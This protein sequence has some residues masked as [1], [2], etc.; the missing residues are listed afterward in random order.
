MFSN[1]ILEQYQ[2]LSQT[3]AELLPCDKL[4]TLLFIYSKS[5][6]S[7]ISDEYVR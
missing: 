6:T 2:Y 5:P 3:S 1:A 4:I 7:V